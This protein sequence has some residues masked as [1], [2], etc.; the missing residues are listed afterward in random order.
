L[1]ALFELTGKEELRE[2]FAA[3]CLALLKD[4]A[5]L[6]RCAAMNQFGNVAD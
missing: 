4:E 1:S 2:T 5:S 6:G 3:V